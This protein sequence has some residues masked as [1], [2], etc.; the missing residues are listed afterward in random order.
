MSSLTCSRFFVELILLHLWSHA[1]NCAVNKQVTNIFFP[2]PSG[3][4]NFLTK[5]VSGPNH[6]LALSSV[7]DKAFYSGEGSGCMV[8]V[9]SDEK[10][11]KI[12]WEFWVLKG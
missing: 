6:L 10:Q 8:K 9:L 12:I 2:L 1:L 7:I 3:G 4:G 5:Q 11:P